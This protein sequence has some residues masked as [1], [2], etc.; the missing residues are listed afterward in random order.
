MKREKMLGFRKGV[1]LGK[2]INFR[3]IQRKGE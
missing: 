3:I 2:K 1:V